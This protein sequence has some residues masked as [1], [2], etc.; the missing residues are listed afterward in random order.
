MRRNKASHHISHT[1]AVGAI[2]DGDDLDM[3]CEEKCKTDG[4]TE[5]LA[6]IL[7]PGARRVTYLLQQVILHEAGTRNDGEALAFK[8]LQIAFN[9]Q[10]A[11]N[12]EG[13]T[14]GNVHLTGH[15]GQ[16]EWFVALLEQ[17]ENTQRIG[18]GLGVIAI[19]R[20]GSAVS[21]VG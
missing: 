2:N 12:A 13:R 21:T 1:Y 20:A 19:R 3:A 5:F 11:Q 8:P 18:D 16:R 14:L 15:L 7:H 4:F 10:R 6:Q 9:F 17:F